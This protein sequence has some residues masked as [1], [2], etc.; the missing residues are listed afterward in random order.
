MAPKGIADARFLIRLKTMEP[1]VV[2][3]ALDERAIEF[4]KQAGLPTGMTDFSRTG[5]KVYTDEPLMKEAQVG[6]R[7]FVKNTAPGEIKLGAACADVGSNSMY[8][9]F[10]GKAKI[11]R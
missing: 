10:F 8:F 7:L 11:A 3:L 1:C 5:L 6:N 2:F 4:Y 9:A